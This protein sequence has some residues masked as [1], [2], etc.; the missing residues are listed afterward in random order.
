MF[1]ALTAF[2]A[3]TSALKGQ[4]PPRL[5]AHAGDVDPRLASRVAA[6]IARTWGTD[7]AGLVMSWGTG[8]LA[9]VPDTTEF[10]LLGRGE[11]GWFAVTFDAA[12]RQPVAIRL[13]AGIAGQRL[14]A[15]RALRVGM[16]LV[17]GDIRE[18]PFLQWGP[19]MP[20]SSTPGPGWV[21]RRILTPGD[22]L[23]LSRVAPP[24]LVEAG[25]PVRLI[26][27]E[28]SVSIALEGIALHA[29][30]MG[31]TVRV[32][33]GGRSGVLLGTVTALGEARMQ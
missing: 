1:S 17:E 26:W 30:A 3:V 7:T 8:S 6:Q 12:G 5:I 20:E 14:V 16:R 4:A 23:D 24:P 28:G 9:G 33:T 29:A 27:N 21:V 31:E 13:R 10:H 15:A 18:E 22:P 25:Q 19:P 11:G 32:R 2:G